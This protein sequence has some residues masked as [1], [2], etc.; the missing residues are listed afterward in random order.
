MRAVTDSDPG[1]TPARGVRVSHVY[2][3]PR[4][5][6]F[7]AWVGAGAWNLKHWDE[8]DKRELDRI[9]AAES[10]PPPR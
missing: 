7:K 5:A 10:V 1:E 6:V 9:R 4:E 8:I 3:A 2:D